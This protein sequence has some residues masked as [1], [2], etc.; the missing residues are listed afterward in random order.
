MI[1]GSMRHYP[2]GKKKKTDYWKKSKPRQRTFKEHVPETPGFWRET[3]QI[4]SK[5]V[6]GSNA[7]ENHSQ[8][9]KKEISG[10]YTIA[11]AYNKGAYQVIPR[12]EVEDIGK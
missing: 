5:G 2:S 1:Y 12:N 11:P 4:P 6:S 10:R 8:E 7:N 9:Y 3:P